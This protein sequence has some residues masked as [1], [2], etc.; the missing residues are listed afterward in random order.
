MRHGNFLKKID[1]QGLLDCLVLNWG[2]GAYQIISLSVRLN[3]TL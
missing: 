1:D 2:D 3:E